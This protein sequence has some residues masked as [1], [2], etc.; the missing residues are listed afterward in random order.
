MGKT[1][2]ITI[3]GITYRPSNGPKSF[4]NRKGPVCRA[5]GAAIEEIIG[6]WPPLPLHMGILD[7]LGESDGLW[8]AEVLLEMSFRPRPWTFF[9]WAAR[10]FRRRTEV[11][12]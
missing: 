8:F 12:Q 1:D 6:E 2:P 4:R 10:E 3:Q 11:I 5:V 9:F 7:A